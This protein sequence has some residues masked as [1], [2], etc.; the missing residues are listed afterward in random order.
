M[1]EVIRIQYGP[2]D[3]QFGELRLPSG[4]GPYPLVVVVH[5]GFW[6]ARYD[7]THIEPVAAALTRAGYATWNI[8]YRRI[9]NPGGGWPGTFTDVALAVDSVRDLAPA[10]HV[11]S[12]RVIIL[13]HSAGGHLALWAAG[14]HRVP[15][16][17][18][19]HRMNALQ[20]H[21]IVSLAGVT[22]LQDAWQL[23]LS[24]GVVRDFMGGTPDEIPDRYAA[25]SPIQLLPSGITQVL[26]HGTA[27]Q[28]VP[29]DLSRR[30]AERAQATG[31][32]VTLTSLPG[33]GHFELV[34]PRSSEWS[35]VL[36]A[37]RLL[38]P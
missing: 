35:H 13:G 10:H 4:P 25:G 11:D 1:T 9:G 33:A 12:Q 19:L 38:L 20:P 16:N 3:F 17:S 8:E 32:H 36:D 28:N 24:G 14:R 7:L 6:R 37:V 29:C 18:P 2:D 23:R 5:G 21:G 30:Y 22:D 27:D 26:L 34:D 31:D 15:S